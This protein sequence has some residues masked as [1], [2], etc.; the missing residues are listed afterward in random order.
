ML[1]REQQEV[2]I[3]YRFSYCLKV[4]WSYGDMLEVILKST[5]N[6][7]FL[8]QWQQSKSLIVERIYHKNFYSSIKCKTKWCHEEL[9]FF[10]I[11]TTAPVGLGLPP[12]NSP[13][14]FGF[15]LNHRQS[16][17]LLGQVISSSQGLYL[18]TNTEQRTYPNTDA[19]NGIRTHDR[20]FR[21]SED[22][23]CLRPLGYRDRHRHFLGVSKWNSNCWNN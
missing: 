5:N 14:H 21:A 15:L 16:V 18:Y 7:S 10:F 2:W 1:Q 9:N 23:T 6:P 19:L 22:S 4:L 12:W 13:F 17:G 11:G 8:L 20:G 3:V